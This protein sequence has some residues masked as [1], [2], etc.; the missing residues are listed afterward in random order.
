MGGPDVGGISLA[1]GTCEGA[2][3]G[4]FRG[5]NHPRLRPDDVYLP[6]FQGVIENE[7][8]ARFAFDLRGYGRPRDY[9]REVAGAIFHSTGDERYG[10]PNDTVA[11]FTGESRERVV[12]LE[13][14]ELVWEPA[15]D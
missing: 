2:L 11:V 3:A 1:Q 14:A 8:G 4:R 7:D 10:R 13:V 15:A 6:D 5:L 9:G 12:R